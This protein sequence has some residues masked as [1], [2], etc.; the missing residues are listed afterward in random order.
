MKRNIW[1]YLPKIYK[2]DQWKIFALIFLFLLA[3]GVRIGD[4]SVVFNNAK[5]ICFSCI[6]IE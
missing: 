5:V 2:I 1:I 3:Y 4:S 6:G